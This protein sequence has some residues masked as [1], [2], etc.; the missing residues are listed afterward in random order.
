[1]VELM[2]AR[3]NKKIFMFELGWTEWKNRTGPKGLI[4]VTIDWERRNRD[5][6]LRFNSIFPFFDN[7]KMRN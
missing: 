7:K 1:M 5:R 3:N 4:V 2:T 6:L